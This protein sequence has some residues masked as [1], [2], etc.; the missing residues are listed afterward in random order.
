MTVHATQKYIRMSA[1]KIR[2]VADLVRGQELAQINTTLSALNK[3]AARVVNEV[4][5]QAVANGVNNLGYSE[6]QLSLKSIVVNEGPTYK[7]VIAKSRGRSGAILKRTSHISV[8]LAVAQAEQAAPTA[9]AEKVAA[10]VAVEAPVAEVK[11]EPKAE[12]SVKAPAKKAAPKKAA[13]KTTKK[14]EA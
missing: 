9:K 2:L 1:R 11:A 4:I 13:T 7:R 6:T 3:R 14:K 5:R 8:E 12:K 10:P